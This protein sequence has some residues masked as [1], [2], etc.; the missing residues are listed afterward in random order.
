MYITWLGQG[1]FKIQSKE[2]TI[3]TDPY[4]S[5]YTG[6]S[7]PRLK[8]DI[9]T[10]SHQ[11]KDHNNTKAIKDNPFII[12]HPGEYEIK[13]VFI[14]GVTSWHDT[15]EGK[16]RGSNIIF[17]F[18]IENMKLVHLGDLGTALHDSQLEAIDGVDILL[19]PVGGVYTIDGQKAAEVV[20]QLEPRIVI[21][22]HYKIPKLKFKLEGVEKFC[23]EMG[24]DKNN[25]EEKIRVTSKDLPVDERKVILLKP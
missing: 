11:H 23:D 8:G 16:E 15:K 21:P 22:M 3:I 24:V 6:L 18:E 5:A 12:E 1:C 7:L 25:T 4:D 19:I 10:V 2:A 14:Q 13:G 9:V 17:R 20:S